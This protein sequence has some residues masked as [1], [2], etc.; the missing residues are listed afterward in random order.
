MYYQQRGRWIFSASL[1]YQYRSYDLYNGYKVVINDDSNPYRNAET[2]RTRYAGYRGNHSQE[3]IR[4][5]QDSRYFENRNHPQ[6]NQWQRNR[7]RGN[8][9]GNGNGRN[10]N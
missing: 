4:N 3:V 5:S 10:H 2:Y 8:G 6:H 9:N 7:N 1:P